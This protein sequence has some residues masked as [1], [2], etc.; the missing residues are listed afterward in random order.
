[1]NAH[2]SWL[3]KE[4]GLNFPEFLKPKVLKA[5]S[6][7]CRYAWLWERWEGIALLMEK[8]QGR[9]PE[10]RQ[11]G[12]KN[13]KTAWGTQQVGYL[14]LLE[15]VSEISIHRETPSG[16]KELG[17]IISFPTPQHTQSSAGPTQ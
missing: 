8:R 1:M 11:P 9:Q 7:K 15:L 16:T 10:N 3:E 5:W 6:F 4:E 17:G 2:S 12:N 13:L 14:L